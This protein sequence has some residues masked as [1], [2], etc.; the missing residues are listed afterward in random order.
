MGIALGNDAALYFCDAKRDKIGRFDLKTHRIDEFSIPSRG[1]FAIRLCVVGNRVYFTEFGTGKLG[2]FNIV[3]RTFEEWESP[4][5][6]FSGP[7]A[8][9]ADGRGAI[10]YDEM[11]S[12]RLVR[13]DPNSQTFAVQN[14]SIQGARASDILAD[15]RGRLWF[16]FPARRALGL[17]QDDNLEEKISR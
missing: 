10:W 9:A 6:R 7:N 3:D 14:P 11:W 1:A 8:I 16:A 13:F 4:G 12:G 2:R 5:L 17:L 15:S